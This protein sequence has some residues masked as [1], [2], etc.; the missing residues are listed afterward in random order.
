M[1]GALED[2][3]RPRLASP[4]PRLPGLR[5]CAKRCGS[6]SLRL[7]YLLLIESVYSA[8]YVDSALS[9]QIS[10][11]RSALAPLFKRNPA[12]KPLFSILRQNVLEQASTW[13]WPG[14]QASGNITQ[15]RLYSSRTAV[16]WYRETGL[17]QPVTRKYGISQNGIPVAIPAASRRRCRGHAATAKS[18]F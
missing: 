9:K 11:Q 14:K 13:D 15:D 5:G 16:A 6:L 4:R 10:A 2:F 1:G 7:A 17:Y 18:K 3:E 8:T 12:G